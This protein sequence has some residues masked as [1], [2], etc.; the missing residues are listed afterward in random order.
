MFLINLTFIIPQYIKNQKPLG[1]VKTSKLKLFHSNVLSSN[2]LHTK[3]IDQINQENLDIILLQEVD[4]SWVNSLSVIKS[5]YS[6]VIERPRSDNFGIALYS[7]MPILDYQIHAITHFELPTIEAKI[8]TGN[9]FFYLIGTHPPPPVNKQYYDNRNTQISFIAQTARKIKGAK[10]VLGDFN[11]TIWSDDYTAF[12]SETGLFN[13]S[14]G[15]GIIPTWP[16]NLIPFM[17]PIDHCLV[18]NHF[19]VKT[20]K[21]GQ[22]IGSDHLPLVIE[23]EF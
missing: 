7:N 19:N 9:S 4:N 11:T 21:S 6:H 5:T 8:K 18:S 22:P 16:T 12:E 20:I 2:T 14:K 13:A 15:F 1:G 23:L 10:I 17:I 3:L